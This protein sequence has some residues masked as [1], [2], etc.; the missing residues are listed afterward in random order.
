[1]TGVPTVHQ[2]ASSSLAQRRCGSLDGG[3]YASPARL[4]CA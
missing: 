4:S 1:M 2:V 3:K